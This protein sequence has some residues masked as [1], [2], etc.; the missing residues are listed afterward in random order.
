MKGILKQSLALASLVLLSATAAAQI[1]D[2][3][4]N[5]S[6]SGT[7]ANH[8]SNA[9]GATTTAQICVFCHTPHASNT[10]NVN[11]PLWNKA[12]VTTSYT[13]YTT[14]QSPTLDGE[15]LNAFGSV[16]AACLSCHD[17][18]QAMDSMINAP[19]TGGYNSAG[20]G[21]GYTWVGVKTLA[22]TNVAKL[23]TDLRNDH[24]IGVQ[25]CGGGV[26]GS[27]STVAGSCKDKDFYGPGTDHA[28]KV[29]TAN[30]NNSQVF[31]VD[32]GT[33]GSGTREKSDMI[34]YTRAFAVGG[35]GPSVEC[36]SC[37]DPH[38]AKGTGDMNFMR[39]TTAGSAIC[40]S[41]HVK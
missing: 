9:D 12:F 10:T 37:H 4:H 40:L 34:L 38:Q 1:K 36:A 30:V 6:S 22:D 3:P 31:W 15:V 5:L 11:A 8:A 24:P 33:S 13:M 16:S 35:S 21:S 41:C 14:T 23:G 19:G 20:A 2:T 7:G 32:T 18:A 28:N 29:K 17:G 27:E 25:Y 39:V 26:T